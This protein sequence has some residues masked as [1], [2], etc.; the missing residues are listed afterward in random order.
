MAYAISIQEPYASRIAEGKKVYETRS[1][2][3]YKY[4]G[5]IYIH[6]SKT[7]MAPKSEKTMELLADLSG[8][9]HPG[10][11]VAKANLVDVITMTEEWI[12]SIKETN[13]EEYKGGFY[14]VGRV[15]LVLED[16]EA[17][18]PIPAK[19]CLGIWEWK[20]EGDGKDKAA[21]D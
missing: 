7:V 8:S 10:C 20:G 3:Q 17:I 12:R 19:G 15:A 1:R 2:W 5:E 9:I 14:E 18:E 21:E 16:V 13:P 11:I 6:A 4:R